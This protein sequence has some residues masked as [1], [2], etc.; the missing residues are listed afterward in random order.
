[1]AAA[2][3]LRGCGALDRRVVARTRAGRVRPRAVRAPARGLR[4]AVRMTG[5]FPCASCGAPVS[6]TFLDLGLMPSANA[7]LREADL[8]A[9]EPRWPL[10][11]AVCGA[12]HLVQLDHH[13]DPGR[14]FR[15]YA[16]FSS[17][18]QSWVEHARRFAGAA[19]ERFGLG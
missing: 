13:L 4:A 9:A 7:Y 12:C 5:P 10:R 6:E 14:L 15:S 17:Y 3:G 1:M 11:A 16:Y 19:I 8:G 18:A 2:A